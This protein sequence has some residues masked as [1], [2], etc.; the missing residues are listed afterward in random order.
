MIGE[1]TM[2]VLEMLRGRRQQAVA[3]S[4]DG[5]TQAARAVAAGEA[6]DVAGLDTALSAV[7][8][9]PEQFDSLVIVCR[10]R[11]E[12][13]AKLA[14]MAAA[15]EKA[16]RLGAQIAAATAAR[17]KILEEHNSRIRVMQIEHAELDAAIQAG[18]MARERLLRQDAPGSAGV[19]LSAADGEWRAL[20]QE[21]SRLQREEKSCREDAETYAAIALAEE[22]KNPVAGWT[23]E[24]NRAAARTARR[25]ADAAA[26]A[27]P[28]AEAAAK[29]ARDRLREAQARALEG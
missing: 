19:E 1:L 4:L 18:I 11:G 27:L 29:A 12:S 8:M 25:A 5:I 2:T 28:A 22:N 20:E 15:E 13:R 21:L 10:D 14:A 23:D 17:D 7:Q 24:G 9:T 26:A 6:V 16:V 3:L